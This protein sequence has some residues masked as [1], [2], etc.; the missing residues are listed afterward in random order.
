[1]RTDSSI[2]QP[3][4]LWD[5]MLTNISIGG[6]LSEASL[7]GKFNS[8]MK[9]NGSTADLQPSQL[10]S[11]SFDAFLAAQMN[12]PQGPQPVPQQPRSSI[13]DA[14]DTCH[15][16]AFQKFSSS[17]KDT[18]GLGGN[19][20]CSQGAEAEKFKVP[21]GTEFCKKIIL[22][23]QQWNSLFFSPTESFCWFCFCIFLPHIYLGA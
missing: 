17:E 20:S 14:E 2:G 4:L 23:L 19:I 1:M 13:L 3:S 18:L 10:I 16:F 8:E 5:D 15:A 12:H 21:T 9:S 7:Q 6:L 11:D 22:L